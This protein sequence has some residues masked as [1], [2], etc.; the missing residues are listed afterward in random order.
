V[1]EAANNG[2]IKWGKREIESGGVGQRGR[3]SLLTWKAGK[4][5]VMGHK[6]KRACG[7]GQGEKP[8]SRRSGGGGKKNG[9]GS[10]RWVKKPE[11]K[12]Q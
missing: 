10:F 5:G 8:S 11:H 9:D 12:R 7:R 4:K 6:K 1:E 3:A 2:F